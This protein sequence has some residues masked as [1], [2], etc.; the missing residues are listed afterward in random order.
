MNLRS[1]A[2]PLLLGLAILSLAPPVAAQA[3]DMAVIVN[4]GNA[5]TN[6][7]LGDLRKMFSGAKRSWAGGQ[8]IKLITRGP[9][10]LERTV[11]L[12]LLAMSE[13]EYK[14][15]WTA[16]VFRGEADA[17]PLI[18]PSVGMQKEALKVFPGGI[19]LVSVHDLRPDM[20]VL[21]VDNLLPGAAGYPLH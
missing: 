13:S 6:V 15:Y 16:Q 7:S 10:C 3:G 11:L 12:K 19:S 1:I 21:K 20:K 2:I 14:Q 9:G 5:A 4:S 17:E 18:V 8:P